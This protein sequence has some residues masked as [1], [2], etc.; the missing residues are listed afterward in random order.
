LIHERPYL[1]NF[2]VFQPDIVYIQIGGNDLS[3]TTSSKSVASEI[4]SFA[5]FLHFGFHIP[6]VIIGELLFRNPSK[7]GKDCND[8]VVATNVSILQTGL[9]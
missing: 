3:N 5:N 2:S 1:Y 7:V 6:I 4:F 9:Q 8:K